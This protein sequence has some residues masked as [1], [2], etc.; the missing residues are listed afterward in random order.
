[1]QP[2]SRSQVR[3]GVTEGLLLAVRVLPEHRRERTNEL[4]HCGH[5]R[6]GTSAEHGRAG[7]EAD[8]TSE[9]GEGEG[10]RAGESAR[11]REGRVREV[12]APGG[13]DAEGTRRFDLV[14][15]DQG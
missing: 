11:G 7:Q 14:R 1:M 3:P 13:T 2:V 8:R 15:R 12:E 6:T 4:L 10:D 9:R 5:T